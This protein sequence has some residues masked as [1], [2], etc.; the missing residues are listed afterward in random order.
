MEIRKERR[1]QSRMKKSI[2]EKKERVG[3]K[4]R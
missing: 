4:E 2:E 1:R 3:A